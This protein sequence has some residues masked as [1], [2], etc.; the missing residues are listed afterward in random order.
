MNI[1]IYNCNKLKTN[2]DNKLLKMRYLLIILMFFSL[3]FAC[4]AQSGGLNKYNIYNMLKGQWV[5]HEDTTF[6]ITISGDTMIE[7]RPGERKRF[8]FTIDKET[9]DPDADTKFARKSKL[10]PTGFYFNESSLGYD[11]V[12]Y[13]DIL[14][15][16]SDST[17]VW[18]STGKLMN[19]TRK[20]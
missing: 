7:K 6:I 14:V 18:F 8:T 12:E 10:S 3:S 1:C 19:L 4:N 5:S 16:I 20:K 15:S 2:K 11:G 13:C 9:C 17:M